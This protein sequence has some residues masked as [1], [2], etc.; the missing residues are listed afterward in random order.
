MI[1]KIVK[2]ELNYFRKV[3][4]FTQDAEARDVDESINVQIACLKARGFGTVTIRA[5]E[6]K[7]QEVTL[8]YSEKPN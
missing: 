3:I 4:V 7:I 1:K 8:E 5:S 2:R 6:K